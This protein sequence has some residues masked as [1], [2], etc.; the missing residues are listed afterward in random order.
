MYKYLFDTYKYRGHT[1]AESKLAVTKGFAEFESMKNKKDGSDLISED[2]FGGETTE[3]LQLQAF[4][5]SPS[6]PLHSYP[7]AFVVVQEYAFTSNVSRR[8]EGEHVK[9]KSSTK[10][11]FRCCTPAFTC[12]RQRKPQILKLVSEDLAWVIMQ[13]PKRKLHHE[14]LEHKYTTAEVNSFTLP[15][16]HARVYGYDMETHFNAG[17][18]EKQ[19]DIG[20]FAALRNK[21]FA[22][23]AIPL[24]DCMWQIIDFLKS[25]FRPGMVRDTRIYAQ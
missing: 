5:T 24:T 19:K 3:S 10:R 4:A 14:L 2:L 21:A 13:W 20:H 11:T 18:A 6:S 8:V 25:S 22:S 23:P 9:T 12:A 7:E 1:L 17:A 16:R 15:Q